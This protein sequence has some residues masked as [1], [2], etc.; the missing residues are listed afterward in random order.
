MNIAFLSTAN[1]ICGISEH[2]RLLG[3]HLRSLGHNVY[4][5]SQYVSGQDQNQRIREVGSFTFESFWV[6]VWDHKTEMDMDFI[7]DTCRRL[8]VEVFHCQYEACLYQEPLLNELMERLSKLNLKIV[9]TFHSSCITGGINRNLIHSSVA[10]SEGLYNAL[11]NMRMSRVY[12][13]PPGIVN[14]KPVVKSFGIRGGQK[15]LVQRVCD[16]LGYKYEVLSPFEKWYEFDD[17]MNQLRLAD[18]IVLYY[19]PDVSEVTS[20]AV[21]I[22]LASRRPVI[23]NDTNWFKDISSPTV[24]KVTSEYGLADV[25]QDLLNKDYIDHHDWLKVAQ[26]HVDEVYS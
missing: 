13:V 5:F 6:D 12:L 18:A 11:Q 23:V 14:R 20:S 1:I 15:E 22:A 19:P 10:H 16:K 21:R 26:I 3:G 24:Y 17:L 9:Y 2:T 7:V 8:N 4:T 25:L